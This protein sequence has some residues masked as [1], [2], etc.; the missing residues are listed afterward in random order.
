[1]L[2]TMVENGNYFFF[3][4][5][6]MG[7]AIGGYARLKS[8]RRFGEIQMVELS[9]RTQLSSTPTGWGVFLKEDTAFRFWVLV[10][11]ERLDSRKIGLESGQIR[12]SDFRPECPELTTALDAP[13]SVATGSRY[14][15]KYLLV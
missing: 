4:L 10:V 14:I 6:W 1:M 15:F 7:A 2:T 8:R 9:R 12:F 3:V 5:N 11:V 13:G